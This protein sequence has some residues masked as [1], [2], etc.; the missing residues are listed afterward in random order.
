MQEGSSSE[1][2]ASSAN[3]FKDFGIR[4]FIR[5]DPQERILRFESLLGGRRVL[6]RVTKVLEQKW[7]SAANGFRKPTQL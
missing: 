2:N 3:G 5:M 1:F 7:L 4:A 6:N